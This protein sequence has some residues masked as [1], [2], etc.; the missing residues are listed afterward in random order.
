MKWN[1]AVLSLLEVLTTTRSHLGHCALAVGHSGPSTATG[2]GHGGGGR[3]G[4]G[5]G[6]DR[7]CTR[8]CTVL[9]IQSLLSRPAL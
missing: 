2:G 3:G 5:G 9:W 6:G 1:T 8:R 4:G 7:L